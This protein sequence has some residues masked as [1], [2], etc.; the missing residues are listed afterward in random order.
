MG[1]I[2]PKIPCTIGNEPST[3]IY[4]EEKPLGKRQTSLKSKRKEK[5]KRP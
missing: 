2:C 5:G 3:E 4:Q 1:Q